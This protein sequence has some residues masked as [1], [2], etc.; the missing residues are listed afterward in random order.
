MESMKLQIEP[1]ESDNLGALPLREKGGATHCLPSQYMSFVIN[2]HTTTVR[3][4]EKY[5]LI[6][7]TMSINEHPKTFHKLH[8][9][10]YTSPE[11]S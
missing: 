4:Y 11:C 1:D 2:D 5:I 9:N 3:N 6:K 7:L 10:S 8:N